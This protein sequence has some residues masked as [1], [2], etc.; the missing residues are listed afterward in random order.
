M[1]RKHTAE[2]LVRAAV[3]GEMD[4]N[5]SRVV[6]TED[7]TWLSDWHGVPGNTPPMERR[8]W[9]CQECWDRI[10]EKSKTTSRPAILVME[11]IKDIEGLSLKAEVFC[12]GC[13]DD[14]SKASMA[15]VEV[16]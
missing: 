11:R 10:N 13:A 9:V 2:D 12:T 4:V 5:P 3:R 8:R 7:G 1:S 15:Y 16:Y 6:Q 14:V